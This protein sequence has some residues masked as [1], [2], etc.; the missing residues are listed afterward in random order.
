VNLE[1]NKHQNKEEEADI[2]KQIKNVLK[3]EKP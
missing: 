2:T 3:G 1:D